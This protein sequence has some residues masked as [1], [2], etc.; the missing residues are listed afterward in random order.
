MR[1][2]PTGKFDNHSA[3]YRHI[4]AKPLA[5]AIGAEICGVDIKALKSGQIEEIRQSWP[6][7]R[8]RRIDAYGAIQSRFG[9]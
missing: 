8:D 5:A 3:A 7:L 6:F 2:H 4:E 9:E 1:L